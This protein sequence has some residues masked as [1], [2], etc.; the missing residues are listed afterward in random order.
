MLLV[1]LSFFSKDV[2]MFI[3]K[4]EEV[5]TIFTKPEEKLF[6][7]AYFKV[8]QKTEKYIEIL[9]RNTNHC[10]VMKKSN[11]A[12]SHLISIFHKHSQSDSYYH[13]HSKAKTV[14]QAIMQIKNHD[15]Y[16]LSNQ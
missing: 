15:D 16:V 11:S 9:S 12:Q 4:R 7:S 10:W 2:I 5:R 1:I 8:L 13:K 6:T 3:L 14:K